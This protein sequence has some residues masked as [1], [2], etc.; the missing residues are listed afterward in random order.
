MIIPAQPNYSVAKPQR[1]QCLMKSASGMGWYIFK[2]L[3]KVIIPQFTRS[4][5]ISRSQTNDCINV[6]NDTIQEF[7][8]SRIVN[9]SCARVKSNLFALEQTLREQQTPVCADVAYRTQF[10]QS[11]SLR[12]VSQII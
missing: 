10:M 8:R 7:N 11:S 3:S 1:L 6:F 12:Q 5:R 9:H 4:A 2:N